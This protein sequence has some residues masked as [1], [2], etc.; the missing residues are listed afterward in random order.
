[1]GMLKCRRFLW[2]AG[3]APLL[4]GCAG[5]RASE[6]PKTVGAELRSQWLGGQDDRG[7]LK[8]AVEES[9]FPSAA[10]SGIGA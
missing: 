2:L 8:K 9:D 7:A 5:P 10:E 3:V 4:V 6:V 1:M